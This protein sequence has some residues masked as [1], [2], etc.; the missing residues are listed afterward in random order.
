M[1][2]GQPLAVRRRGEGL[3][4]FLGTLP[5][6]PFSRVVLQE[7]GAGTKTLRRT[8]FPVGTPGYRSAI[9]VADPS[10]ERRIRM[11]EEKKPAAVANPQ[12]K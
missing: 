5:F 7:A 3:L 12:K 1:T 8:G 6:G 10:I 9:P 11:P 4:V 2:V